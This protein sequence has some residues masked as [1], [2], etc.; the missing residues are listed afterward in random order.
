MHTGGSGPVSALRR[1]TADTTIR[2]QVQFTV[3]RRRRQQ[4]LSDGRFSRKRELNTSLWSFL[5][6]S[7]ALRFDQTISYSVFRDTLIRLPCTGSLR[8]PLSNVVTEHVSK[9]I[10]KMY[11]NIVRFDFS[12]QKE[13]HAHR[14]SYTLCPSTQ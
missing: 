13:F 6:P 8:R 12:S 7:S 3:S 1:F 10:L 4:C 14:S 9:L 2:V 11:N 5:R